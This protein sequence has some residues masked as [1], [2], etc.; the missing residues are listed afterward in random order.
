MP[1]PSAGS[2]SALR[3]VVCACQQPIRMIEHLAQVFTDCSTAADAISTI[4]ELQTRRLRVVV[5]VACPPPRRVTPRDGDPVS[6]SP[7]PDRAGLPSA[8]VG[9][10]NAPLAHPPT[11]TW[12]SALQLRHAASNVIRSQS[13]SKDLHSSAPALT[14]KSMMS[15]PTAVASWACRLATVVA[16]CGH[17][18]HPAAHSVSLSACVVRTLVPRAGEGG[19]STPRANRKHL[20]E[21]RGGAT[22]RMERR[23]EVLGS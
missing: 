1:P 22:C 19:V 17:V 7:R 11:P 21:Q 3:R 6:L 18:E 14:A 15:W 4:R 20:V 8:L 10:H 5:A 9:R 2:L 13:I 12:M 23:R 16:G